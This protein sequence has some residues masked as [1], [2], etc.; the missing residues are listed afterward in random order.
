MNA[1]ARDLGIE[2]GSLATG[3][4]NAITDVPGVRVGQVTLVSGEGRLEVGVGPVRTGVTVVL[5][6]ETPPWEHPVFAAAHSLNG[7]GEL[8]G[9]AWLSESGLLCSPIA[10]TSTHAVGTVRD[11]LVAAEARLRDPHDLFWRLP[12]VAETWDGLL[13]DVNGAH[14]RAEHATQAWE[15]AASGPV[16]EGNI[17]GGTGMV[18]HGFKGGI[19]TASRVLP[20]S[21]GRFT[22]GV[23]LQA[24]HGRRERL[25]IDGVPVGR[26]LCADEVPEPVPP[27]PGTPGPGGGSVVAV[28]ATD[29]PLL[30]NQCR[31]LAQR[32]SLGI[33][34]TGGAGEHWSGDIFV[35]FSTGN[36]DLPAG[37]Y[38]HEPQ[39]TVPVQML[40]NAHLDPLYDAVVESTEEAIVNAL[41]AAR[42]M[43]GRDSTVAY[44]IDH[45]RLG[46][47]MRT[48]RGV[49]P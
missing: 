41:V 38:A 37:D 33:A 6:R 1:R 17:G 14:V 18:C 26:A 35:A 8:T 44:G 49:R 39:L 36:P 28:V 12:V 42:T 21:A 30:P 10:L 19:G 2:P 9:L 34:R 16:G 11:A 31:W 20:A 43:V 3:T 27:G 22:V 23:L 5:P 47:V 7:N 29:A 15:R 40:A 32:A 25:T 4:W 45:E 24:N 46:Q 13:N 48:W